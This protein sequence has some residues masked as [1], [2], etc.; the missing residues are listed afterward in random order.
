MLSDRRWNQVIAWAHTQGWYGTPTKWSE[1]YDIV[2]EIIEY[3]RHRF[4]FNSGYY[5][6]AISEIQ[7]WVFEAKEEDRRRA[8]LHTYTTYNYGRISGTTSWNSYDMYSPYDD[9]YI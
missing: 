5:A 4:G 3:I 2:E 9:S 7:S 8:S 1:R 6:G